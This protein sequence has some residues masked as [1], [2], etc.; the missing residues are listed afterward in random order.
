MTPAQ[1]ETIQK[2]IQECGRIIRKENKNDP[3]TRSPESETIIIEQT[4]K[5][6]GLKYQ[7]NFEYGKMYVHKSQ[8]STFNDS[9]SCRIT[10]NKK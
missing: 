3:S 2:Q 4:M 9:L 7:L 5:L 10:D 6:L 8:G 1:T